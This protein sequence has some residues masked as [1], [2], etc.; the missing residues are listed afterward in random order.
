MTRLWRPA[1][2]QIEVRKH[3]FIP[4]TSH[5]YQAPPFTYSS[6]VQ[7]RN[8]CVYIPDI[9][10]K[11]SDE[12]TKASLARLFALLWSFGCVR[13]VAFPKGLD[14]FDAIFPLGKVEA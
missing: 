13:W 2:S 10:L 12:S 14:C 6:L 3:L 4:I 1:S 7:P 5:E 9:M 8:L 11:M